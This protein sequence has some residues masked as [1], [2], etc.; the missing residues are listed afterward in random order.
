M[1]FRRFFTTRAKISSSTFLKK[2]Y[3]VIKKVTTK[4]IARSSL[5]SPI[6]VFPAARAGR[7]PSASRR[8]RK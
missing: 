5:R 4:D 6:S 1:D 3:A 7:R 8:T 2:F